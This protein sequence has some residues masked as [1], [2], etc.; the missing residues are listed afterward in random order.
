[1]SIDNAEILLIGLISTPS[2]F[3]TIFPDYEGIGDPEKFHPYIIADSYTN[4]VVNMIK[5]VN[6][7]SNE[8]QNNDNFQLNDQL[9]LISY[10]LVNLKLLMKTYL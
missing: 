2:G 9:F 5:A 4:S 10:Y 6:Q 8:L 7:L 3:I 1:M